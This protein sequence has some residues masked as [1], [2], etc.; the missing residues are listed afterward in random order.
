MIDHAQKYKN[1]FDK[2]KLD[3][4][5]HFFGWAANQR[6][7]WHNVM[8][9]KLFAFVYHTY[10]YSS[11]QLTIILFWWGWDCTSAYKG[12]PSSCYQSIVELTHPTRV[13]AWR[14]DR[15]SDHNTGNSVPYSL[16]IVWGFFNV[17]R[18]SLRTKVV[19]QDLQLIVLMR[20]DLKV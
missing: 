12:T 19:R 6:T 9:C 17:P 7:S 4:L 11:R 15:R 10:P 16:Q 13:C 20:E 18:C 8:I 5:I 3:W 14:R 2:L 1:R